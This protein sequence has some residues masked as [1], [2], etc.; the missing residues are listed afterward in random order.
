[1]LFCY[2]IRL[3]KE[4]FSKNVINFS[5]K[6]NDLLKNRQL[7]CIRIKY[8]VYKILPIAH[9]VQPRHGKSVSV[10]E[11]SVAR[12]KNLIVHRPRYVNSCFSEI[13][14][15]FGRHNDRGSRLAA[16]RGKLQ[17]CETD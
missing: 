6:R 12:D 8:S 4:M 15:R 5:I 16:R 3:C 10:S 17:R 9:K 2:D 7:I 13:F 1:M 14:E 11:G